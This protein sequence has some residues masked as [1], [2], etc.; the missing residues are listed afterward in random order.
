MIDAPA[1]AAEEQRSA[2]HYRIREMAI[3]R[4]AEKRAFRALSS[5]G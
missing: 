1:I 2:P 3:S 4:G 5:T